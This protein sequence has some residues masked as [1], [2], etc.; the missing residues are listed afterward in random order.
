[1]GLIVPIGKW[2]VR[3]ACRQMHE[4]HQ[5]FPAY[6]HLTISVNISIRQFTSDLVETIKQALSETG[7]NPD[8]LKVEITESVII[9]NP[10][11]ASDIFSR[12]KD[13]N[14]KVQIDDF[15]TGYSSLS[16]L[17]QFS[18]DALK[19][20]RS[21]IKAMLDSEQAMEIVK[22]IVAM[23]RNMKME[24]IAEGVETVKQLEE[25]RTLKCDYFQ[26][27]WFSKP[28]CSSDAETLLAE[29]VLS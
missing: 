17:G 22:T 11:I 15:G 28:L 9:N 5:M 19:I 20:D 7:L 13:L 12:L 18:F 25:L 10:D 21:F 3:E 24:V 2:A 29:H 1:T 23:A 14:I 4:W 26:G 16:Y 8:S 27:Y 6:S